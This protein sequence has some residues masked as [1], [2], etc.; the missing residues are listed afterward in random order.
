MA[1][2]K[3]LVMVTAGVTLMTHGIRAVQAATITEDVGQLIPDAQVIPPGSTTL[4]SITGSLSDNNDVDLFQITLTGGKTF[5]A[6]TEA[7]TDFDPQLF[8]FDEDGFGV[9][10][11]DDTPTSVQPTLPANHPLTPTDPGVY[12]LA[13]ASFDNDPVSSQGL[14][15]DNDESFPY[16]QVLEP[17][18]PGRE[19]PLSGFNN[20]GGSSGGY[21][22]GLTGV[23]AVPE[24]S[25]VLGI[26]AFGAFSASWLLKRKLTS[27]EHPIDGQ[28]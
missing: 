10:A 13:I 18:A 4:D 3:N 12:Y 23:R 19:A 20:L 26:L 21:T 11:R 5:S 7:K 6:T 14:I 28:Q 16:N 25:S 2:W 1:T 9:Y 27:L 22:I 24:T 15:F 17:I 8:L